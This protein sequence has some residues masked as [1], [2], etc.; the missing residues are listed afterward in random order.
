MLRPPDA[1]QNGMPKNEPSMLQ[2]NHLSALEPEQVQS[3]QSPPRLNTS[4]IAVADSSY[5]VKLL[6]EGR[7]SN[8]SSSLVADTAVAVIMAMVEFVNNIAVAVVLTGIWPDRMIDLVYRYVTFG[9]VI[10]QMVCSSMT[11]LP[12]VVIGAPFENL[13]IF[14]RI[15]KSIEAEMISSSL[16]ARMVTFFA[17]GV[18][19]NIITSV[20]LGLLSH[21]GLTRSLS[22]LPDY[23]HQ[24]VCMAI[25]ISLLGLGFESFELDMFALTTWTSGESLLKWVP[26]YILGGIV[27]ICDEFHPSNWWITGFIIFSTVGVH[28]VLFM[29]RVSLHEGAER[30]FLLAE[31]EPRPV[32]EYFEL[33]YGNFDAI[34]WQVVASNLPDI[35]MAAII[36]PVLNVSINIIV[37]EGMCKV[38]VSY[39]V[40]FISHAIGSFL[41]S[42]GF[43]LHAYLAASDTSLLR[44]AG[45]KNGRPAVMMT[46]ILFL[47]CVFPPI[48]PLLSITIPVLLPAALFV[49][50]G[51]SFFYGSFKDMR[52]N[53]SPTENRLA[54]MTCALC[55]LTSIATGMFVACAAC[56]VQ[57]YFAGNP[58]GEN[59][60]GSRVYSKLS[61]SFIAPGPQRRDVGSELQSGI[62][63]L[64]RQPTQ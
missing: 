49:I 27:W 45:G 59:F 14:N 1:H 23:V 44:K 33:T 40:E 35:V 38:K 7:D 17:C 62:R 28:L 54:L 46:T 16:E 6:D 56:V 42:L 50:I 57:H 9:A 15:Q 34:Q 32:Q 55:Y 29:S 48:M 25:G 21:P 3:D 51:M 8:L 53:L 22:V 4:N 30:G 58:P 20:F 37:I 26:A 60:Q 52:E 19:S 5:E 31:L 41:S 13:I 61:H 36:G 63:S 12:G 39:P 10:T 18:V 11:G 47:T 64:S 24:G 2:A 43:S